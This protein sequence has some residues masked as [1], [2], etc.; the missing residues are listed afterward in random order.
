MRHVVLMVLWA[1]TLGVAGVVLWRTT[2]PSAPAAPSA[3][4]AAAS[5]LPPASSRSSPSASFAYSPFQ[6]LPRDVPLDARKVALG[7]RLFADK[8][9]SAD[10]TVSCTSCHD[11]VHGG[12]DARQFSVGV[13]GAVGTRNAPT[14]FNSVFNFRQF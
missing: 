11:L 7:K 12:A 8:G 5:G 10:G 9:L 6:P 2:S 3:D 1:A 13:H 4:S 14:V